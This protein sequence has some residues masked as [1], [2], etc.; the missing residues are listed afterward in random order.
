MFPVHQ[1]NIVLQLS[2]GGLVV[3]EYN[4]VEVSPAQGAL[5]LPAEDSH[6]GRTDVADRVVAL[7]HAPDGG[8]VQTEVAGGHGG[9]GA[10]S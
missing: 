2:E 6:P 3:G 8:G 10:V 5:S 1:V 7:A 4:L 9:G